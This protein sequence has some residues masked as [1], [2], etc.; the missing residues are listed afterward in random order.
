MTTGQ[1]LAG[2]VLAA[3][4]GVGAAWLALRRLE[5]GPAEHAPDLFWL[6]G[7]LA[8]LPAWLVV[9]LALRERLG[10]RKPDPE[11]A[12]W[13]MLSAA[14]ALVGAIVTHARLRRI[15]AAEPAAPGRR[16]W[17][18]GLLTLLPAWGVAALGLVFGGA[19]R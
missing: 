6:A 5:R 17:T 18:T 1:A 19:G 11:V 9:F 10:G 7:V 12:I 8:L 16:G 2:S 4:V 15:G 3:I 14:A 13:W